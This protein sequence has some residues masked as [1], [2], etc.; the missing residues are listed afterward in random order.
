LAL[1]FVF[2]E[3]MSFFLLPLFQS[4]FTFSLYFALNRFT[5]EKGSRSNRS[6]FR[7][8]HRLLKKVWWCYLV[9]G[10][11]NCKNIYP[12]NYFRSGHKIIIKFYLSLLS[13]WRIFD[14]LEGNELNMFF[15][16]AA[17]NNN[18]NLNNYAVAERKVSMF[19]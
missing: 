11:K 16:S 3:K 7:T 18:V 14:A 19:V 5:L 15:S 8:V 6:T 2:T 17:V 1:D 4:S 12:N 9:Q 10:T 13:N